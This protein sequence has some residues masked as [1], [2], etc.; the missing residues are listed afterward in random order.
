MNKQTY[1]WSRSLMVL[2]LCLIAAVLTACSRTE[3]P[4]ITVPAGAQ[5]GDLTMESCTFEIGRESY[6]GG[7]G[8]LTVPENRSD[9]NSRLIALPV[10]RI[11][12]T[13]KNTQP[14]FDLEG[15]PGRPNMPGQIP[16]WLN[17]N[18]DLVMV[19]YR[20][21]EGSI[22]LDLPEFSEALGG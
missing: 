4:T 16:A 14:I 11:R 22:D 10:K 15:G 18:H 9:P 17:R 19:G 12:A 8:I 1:T 21:V 3:E 2:V 5:A 6:V 7:C 13:E 20:G